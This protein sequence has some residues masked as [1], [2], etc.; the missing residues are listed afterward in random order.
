MTP[1][2]YVVNF[3]HP[4]HNVPPASQ[5][6]ASL[7][8]VYR[9]LSC[10][11]RKAAAPILNNLVDAAHIGG[12]PLQRPPPF[13][14]PAR[15]Q[16]RKHSHI[17]ILVMNSLPD[18]LSH[19]PG[20]AWGAVL[21]SFFSAVACNECKPCSDCLPRRP[22]FL[23]DCTRGISASWPCPHCREDCAGGLA[24]G[25]AAC[26]LPNAQCDCLLHGGWVQV[27]RPQGFGGRA[28]RGCS[29]AVPTLQPTANGLV[30]TRAFVIGRHAALHPWHLAPQPSLSLHCFPACAKS[31]Q[32]L[33][34][35]LD[36]HAAAA[37]ALAAR[38]AAGPQRGAAG[39][40]CRAVVARQ[41]PT[42][43]HPL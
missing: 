40:G 33:P 12:A 4:L 10:S 7:S 36:Q 26:R 15:F 35:R 25:R 28:Q 24:G 34:P 32:I 18:T 13:V 38:G 22:S 1:Q 19:V 11:D 39:G 31:L 37:A 42:T 8:T 5:P 2:V 23:R 30:C 16:N 3:D 6:P 20:S 21:L 9:L 14:C 41:G 29:R 27:S 17:P 43:P